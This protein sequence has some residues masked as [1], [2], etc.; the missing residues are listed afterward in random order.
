[1]AFIKIILIL[2]LFDSRDER[3]RT[4]R[5]RILYD[6]MEAKNFNEEKRIT[7]KEVLARINSLLARRF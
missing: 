3:E 1:M 7:A 6:L 4:T 5:D 2:N